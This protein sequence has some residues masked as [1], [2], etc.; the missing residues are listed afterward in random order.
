MQTSIDPTAVHPARRYASAAPDNAV[1]TGLP[2]HKLKR[3]QAF[4]D[5][6]LAE[7]MH[8]DQLAGEVHMSP[9]HFA[10]MFKQT[11][12]QSPHLYVVSQRIERAKALLRDSEVP[13]IAIAAQTGFRTQGH[14]TGVFRRYTGLTPR[15]FRLSCRVAEV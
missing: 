2:Q 11:T 9:F 5:E 13:L 10:R 1:R 7:A 6:H 8:V 4:V 15:V 12:G 3:V 14:F